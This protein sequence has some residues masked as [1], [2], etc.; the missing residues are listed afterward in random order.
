MRALWLTGHH[1]PRSFEVRERPDPLPAGGQVRIRVKAAGLNFADLMA[2]YGLY[3]DAPRPPCVLG[4]EASGIVDAVG[5]GADAGL[6]GTHAIALSKFGAHADVLCVPAQN[7]VKMPDAMTFE[8]AAALPVNYVTAYHMLHRVAN[9]R[10]GESVLIHQAA[11]GVGTA[12]LQLCRDVAGVTFGTASRAKHDALRAQGC[13]YPIDYRST[14]YADEVRRITGGRGVDVVLDALGGTDWR[15]GYSLLEPCGRLVCFGFANLAA[16][17]KRN[18]PRIAA[19]LLT[20]PKF[21]PLKLMADNR[22]VAGVNIGH[23]DFA[24]EM[25]AQ[26]MRDILRLYEAGIVKPLVDLAVP[27]AEAA[28]GLRR[29]QQ[30]K[31][32][33]KVLCIP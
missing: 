3:P 30:G 18:L 28:A 5:E 8:E 1:G 21:S 17:G 33:G 24:S 13:T 14:D 4:Y 29:L 32:I 26:E 7:V 25:L 12:A 9:L 19:Q 2:S 20:L 10:Q 15:K 23:L 27:F 22:A 11:G 6:V 16:R 31:N